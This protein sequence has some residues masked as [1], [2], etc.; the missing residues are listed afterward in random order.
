M[1][2]RTIALRLLT[3]VLACALALALGEAILRAARLP[4]VTYHSYAY[5][6]LSGGTLYPGSRVLYKSPRG[7][8]VE[9]RVNRWGYLDVDHDLEK[10]SATVRIGFFGDSYVAA[11]QVPLEGTFFRR[12][13]RRLG[14]GVEV[15]AF[16]I[17]GRGT[18]Q[19][20]L[21]CRQRMAAFDL[22]YVVYVFCDNDPG[23]QLWEARRA[24]VFP[25]AVLEGDSFRVDTT[26]RAY[27]EKRSRGIYRAWQALKARSLVLSTIDQR[28]KL[29]KQYGVRARVPRAQ[30]GEA[31]RPL[32]CTVP[33]TWPSDSLRE[34]AAELQGRVMERWKRDVTADGRRFA[35]LYARWGE[36]REPP[37]E[38]DSWWPWLSG[39]CAAHGIA[40]IDPTPQLVARMDRGL[41]VHGDHYT[42]DG[43]E[44]LAEAF[45]AHWAREAPG[46][47]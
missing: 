28:L 42:S 3:V 6:P 18:I 16:G 14:N 46:A 7:E 32:P 39:F 35:V 25:Y 30:L 23:D 5:D 26:T 34:R 27:Y 19:S 1:L 17:G 11:R 36:W 29:L 45:L 15:L 24:N 40:L 9:R 47:P 37:Q 8:L 33:S 31:H 43:H 4:G 12:I 41:E 2:R 13:Q 20:C 10:P 44:A 38:Q 21:D 22:D